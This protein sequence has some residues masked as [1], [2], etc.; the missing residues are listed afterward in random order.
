MKPKRSALEFIQDIIDAGERAVAYVSQMDFE[1]FAADA[2]AKDAVRMCLSDMGVA[3]DQ[4]LKLD[5]ALLDEFPDFEGRKAYE[6]RNI[7]SHAYFGV[8]T[9][10]VWQTLVVSV[11]K[12][13][14]D[15][16]AILACRR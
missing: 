13:V 2:K 12:I 7:L 5:P 15:A 3:A 10:I 9:K 16:R 4:A 8:D 1:E 6:M 14:A 11:P